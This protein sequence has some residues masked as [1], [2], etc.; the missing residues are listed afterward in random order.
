MD[1]LSSFYQQ[2]NLPDWMRIGNTPD[3]APKVPRSQRELQEWRAIRDGKIQAQVDADARAGGAAQRRF[4]AARKGPKPG[5]TPQAPKGVRRI[6]AGLASTAASTVGIELAGQVA[7]SAG[8]P[9]AAKMSALGIVTQDNQ[10]LNTGDAPIYTNP[11]TG[12]QAGQMSYF[13][14]G[15]K[16]QELDLAEAAKIG[17]NYFVGDVEYDFETGQAINP[18]TGDIN[19]DGYSI[20]APVSNNRDADAPDG[21]GAKGTNT[22]YKIDLGLM[23][24]MLGRQNVKPMADINSFV[25]TALPVTPSGDAQG[26]NLQAGSVGPGDSVVE[27]VS[28]PGANGASPADTADNNRA[29]SVPGEEPARNWMEPGQQSISEIRKRAF[30]DFDGNTMQALR[31]ANA[32]VGIQR[33]GDKFFANDGGEL[34]EITEGLYNQVKKGKVTADDLKSGYVTG[35]QSTMVPVETPD[36]TE[37]IDPTTPLSKATAG[38]AEAPTQTDLP[39][40]SYSQQSE[41]EMNNVAPDAPFSK[42]NM[43]DNYFKK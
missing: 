24:D 17:K 37:A 34:K 13:G 30:L 38:V 40:I 22:G 36:I 41:F 18:E 2:I 15:Y 27:G 4:D 31:A 10:L 20:P 21:S 42:A 28:T 23:N 7:R 19:P 1:P 9:D 14:D 12:A 32:A 35:I 5:A 8:Q 6:G 25:A 43:K 26:R 16:E 33:Q 39:G 29:V 11:F 3:P